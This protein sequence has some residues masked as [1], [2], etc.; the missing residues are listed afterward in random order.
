MVLVFLL[1]SL[2]ASTA[3]A[4]C[5]I[6]GGVVIKPVLDLFLLGDVASISF[7]SGNTVLAMTLYSVGMSLL[8][9]EGKVDLR[10][11][12][13]L[14]IGGI[15]GG[16][17]GKQLFECAIAH[18]GDGNTVGAFQAGGLLALT[19]GTLHYTLKR[20][21]IRSHRVGGIPA[22]LGIGA[23]LGLVSTFLGI[24]G[25]PINLVALHYFFS[26]PTKTAAQ[27]SLYIIL[28][29]QAASLGLTL[30]GGTVPD[31][32]PLVLAAMAAGGVGGGVLGR[33]VN[34]R[35]GHKEADKL[36]VG[37]MAVIILICV[38]NLWR[39]TTT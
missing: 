30:A 19:L 29:S 16:V 33:F 20:D 31:F 2:A 36:F 6:G 24:G 15:L 10:L 21:L 22:C 35:I 38:Y 27:N 4:I 39:F 17:A 1:I 25:G 23:G 5:G 8:K 26:M 13:P 3:G 11:G 14:A 37:L 34:K 18:F 28:F 12:T 32:H 9:R 7:L